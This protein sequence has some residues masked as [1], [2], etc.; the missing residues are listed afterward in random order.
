MTGYIVA[1]ALGDVPHGSVGYQTI[2]AVGLVLFCITVMMNIASI[3][4]VKKYRQ[5][6]D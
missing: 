2:F 1:V 3:S 4:L 5:K 6:Y